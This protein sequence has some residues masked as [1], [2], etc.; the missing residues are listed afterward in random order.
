MEKRSVSSISGAGKVGKC[1]ATC[2]RM[3][4]ERFLTVYTK[5]KWIKD[6]GITLDSITL[7]NIGR[8]LT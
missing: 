7:E 8:T 6:Q 1:T 2:K 3:K 4:I 5:I